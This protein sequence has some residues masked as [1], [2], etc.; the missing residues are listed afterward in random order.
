MYYPPEVFALTDQI[1]ESEQDVSNLF[2][3]FQT[4]LLHNS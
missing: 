4:S 3:V 1:T 2:N